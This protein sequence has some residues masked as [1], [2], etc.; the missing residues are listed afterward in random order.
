MEERR[1][2]SNLHKKEIKAA[3]TRNAKIKLAIISPNDRNFILASIEGCAEN[4]I[5]FIFDPGLYHAAF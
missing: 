3:I 5:P 4:K 2:K 1:K